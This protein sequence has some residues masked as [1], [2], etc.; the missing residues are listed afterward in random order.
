MQRGGAPPGNDD[1]MDAYRAKIF[2]IYC[3]L[4]CTKYILQTYNIRNGSIK[5]VCDCLG[6]LTQAI[7]YDNRPTTWHPSFDLLWSIFDLRDEIPIS[8]KWE[9]V[10]GHQDERQPG[11]QLSQLDQLN[12]EADSGAKQYLKHVQE[13]GM[14]PDPH[15][16]ENQWR[17]RFGH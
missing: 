12:C 2:G 4:I 14:R 6:A 13:Y 8:I 10:Y 5:I 3:V 15:L 16:Y 7:V 1:E 17:L 11:R 9:H